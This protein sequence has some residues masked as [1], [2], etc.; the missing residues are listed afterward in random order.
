MPDLKRF[1]GRVA[2]A[3]GP[4]A[5]PERV[6]SISRLLLDE[7]LQ[8]GNTVSQAPD[9]VR[10]SEHRVVVSAMG[11]GIEAVR[12]SISRI[13]T[14]IGGVIVEVGRDQNEER[15]DLFMVVALPESG[16]SIAELQTRLDAVSTSKDATVSVQH[17]ELY[18]AM[19][20]S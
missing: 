8:S 2:D 7:I 3:M 9:S 12:A 15:P 16:I 19:N 18:N 1:V 11:P 14:D 20:R 13:V 5:T 17:E 4:A 10:P 6:E